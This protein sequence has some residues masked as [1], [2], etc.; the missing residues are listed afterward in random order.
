MSFGARLGSFYAA[1]LAVYGVQIPFWPVWLEGKGLTPTDIGLIVAVTVGARMIGNPLAAHI[2]DRSGERRRPMLA[3]SALSLA[4][5]GLFA[6]TDGFWTILAVSVLSSMLF[7]PM[8][9]LGESLTMS[10]V[11]RIGID[12]GRV[13][14]W[15]SLSFIVTATLSGHVLVEAPPQAIL[16]LVLATVALTG[17]ACLILP[18]LR[19]DAAP[20]A[21]GLPIAL[22]MADRRLLLMLAAAGLIQ[23]S[24]AVYYAFG[25]LH[26]EAAG[27][28]DDVIGLLWALGVVCEIVLFAFG[29][30]LLCRVDAP[31]LLA[32]AGGL[33]AVRWLTL[34][35]TTVLPAVIAAQ[36]LHAFSYAAAHLAAIHIIA[37]SVAP[38]L[39]ATAQ[40][41]YAA[42]VM[43][44]ALGVMLL[45]SGPLYQAI[46]GGAY[47]AMAAAASAGGLAAAVLASRK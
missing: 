6:F 24:H 33:A 36:S 40:S 19:S 27:Y 4:A 3:L 22:V 42:L 35:A 47:F 45:V 34:G 23:G 28:G 31:R 15:G 37:A 38:G 20:V 8:M 32:L 10:G 17:A 1:F 44:F 7:P 39:S 21:A 5:Y 30:A 41:L 29:R 25:T 9:A 12:Y 14:L 26:W 16:W 43:G 18:D 11:A 2:A 46:A 13:R